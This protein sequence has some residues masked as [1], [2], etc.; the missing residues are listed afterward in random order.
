VGVWRGRGARKEDGCGEMR[1]CGLALLLQSPPPPRKRAAHM[2]AELACAPRFEIHA[3]CGSLR[4]RES[5]ILQS[6]RPSRRPASTQGSIAGRAPLAG[7]V[8]ARWG[9]R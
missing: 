7:S 6:E 5:N 9:G 8:R 2:P 4:R 1:A 3:N